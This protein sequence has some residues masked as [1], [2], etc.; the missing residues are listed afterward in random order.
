MGITRRDFLNGVAITVA[1]GLT[2][3]QILRASPL[4]AQKTLYYPPALTGLRGNHPGS[5]EHAHQLGRDGKGFDFANVSVEE[6]Y[7]LVVVGAGIS[8]LAAACFWQQLKGKDQRILLIDNHDDFG[9]HAKRNELDSGNATLLG[10]GGSESLQSPRSNFSAVA[11]GLLKSLGVSVDGLEQAFDKT[12]YPDL[13]LSRGVY[14]DKR[15]FG[16]DK[17]VSGD[18]GRMVADDIPRDRL[19]G[20]SYQAFIND[21]P[22]P[23]SDRQAL[24]ALHTIDKDYLPDLS[25]EEK[26][27]WL[28]THSYSQFLRDKVGLSEMAIRYFQQTTSDFQAVGIDATSCSDARICDLPGLNGMKLPPLDAESLADLEDPYVFHFPDGNASLARL[29]VR[30]LIPQVAPAGKDMQD[31][32]LATFDYSQL[33]RPSWPVRLRLSS[34]GLHVAN[35]SDG[36]EVCYMTGDRLHKVHAGQ[37]VMAGYN[38]MIP[39]LVPEMSQQQQEALKQNVK[40]PLVYSKVLIRNWQPFIQLGVHEVYCPTAP[41]CRVKLD[42]PVDLGGYRHP[43]DPSQP[44]GLHMVSVPTLP[45]SGLSP[46]EQARKGR[47]QLLGTSFEQ[48]ER[49]IREQLQGMLGAAGFNHQRDILAITVNR[50][51]HGYSYFLNGLFDDEDEAQKIITT[52][53]QPIGNITIANSDSDWS[54]YANSAIDQAWRAVNELVNSHAKEEA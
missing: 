17:L 47:A 12:F 49:L 37:V 20:R 22:L 8:G 51:S 18:P 11:M 43:R 30:H 19:N 26:V 13:N 53:R 21:F 27:E 9:G 15:N 16:V 2:P 36:V 1:A 5:F 42:Y 10:Y 24:I 34:T 23:E 44:I 52:A 32:V 50:W 29:M 33:D 6:K 4:T 14:F 46:R 31:I 28:D 38:M 40:A 25:V 3:M 39:Y 41:Y 45:G 48:H 7:D 54:P 35:V